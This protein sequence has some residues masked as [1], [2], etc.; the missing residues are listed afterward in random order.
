MAHTTSLG[1]YAAKSEADREDS[2]V[3]N[4]ISGLGLFFVVYDPCDIP[5]PNGYIW[6]TTYNESGR[7]GVGAPGVAMQV[8]TAKP[9]D[10]ANS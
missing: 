9:W 2:A 4:P 10:Q 7:V 8:V 5:T 6:S 3:A 1:A